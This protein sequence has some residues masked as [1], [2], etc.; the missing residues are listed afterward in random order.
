M[1]EFEPVADTAAR[2]A[3]SP[4]TVLRL[5]A[6]GEVAGFRSGRLVRIQRA[7]VDA[8]IA[9]RSSGDQLAPRRRV[10]RKRSA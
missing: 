8:F 1:P 7:S 5:L 4:D 3:C 6:R 9:R 2:L 10:T